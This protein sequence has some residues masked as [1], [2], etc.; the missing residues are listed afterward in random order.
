MNRDLEYSISINDYTNALR[1]FS[2]LPSN[3][4]KARDILWYVRSAIYNN[5]ASSLCRAFNLASKNK[6]P[7]HIKLRIAKEIYSN[8]YRIMNSQNA[9]GDYEI[10]EKL[11]QSNSQINIHS[12]IKI[13]SLLK[14]NFNHTFKTYLFNNSNKF[15][16]K[17]SYSGNGYVN[18]NILKIFNLLDLQCKKNI[19]DLPTI[20]K[21]QE[22]G[23]VYVTHD[24]T[25]MD[26]T[27]KKILYNRY[28]TPPPKKP[29]GKSPAG[30]KSINI[31]FFIG[32]RNKGFYHWFI[33]QFPLLVYHYSQ[34]YSSLPLLFLNNTKL[35]AQET[36]KLLFKPMPNIIYVGDIIKVEKLFVVK[37]S[38]LVLSRRKLNNIVYDPL[39]IN[40]KRITN[41]FSLG[42]KIYISR[43]KSVRRKF[44]NEN[45]LEFHLAK[46]DFK[47]VCLEDLPLAKQISLISNAN[48]IAAC[49]GSGLAHIASCKPGT[50]IF[51]IIP[52]DVS[53]SVS[54]NTWQNKFS[55]ISLSRMLG[56]NHRIYFQYINPL[57][58]E[59][60]L[61]IKNI[62]EDI[63]N[64]IDIK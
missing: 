14:N 1:I 45:E 60:N 54:L 7:A 58:P 10:I 6:I 34:N 39:V 55:F 5:D 9:F 2:D 63:N 37:G 40:S 48:I 57:K 52:T 41:N 32:N 22:F 31:A 38:D 43:K 27:F 20:P 29:I 35:F 42:N 12:L 18:K 50:K 28:L 30:V 19:C 4:F 24:G 46:Y 25:V 59:Y 3:H 33:E 16:S 47:A 17:I 23:N 51:E 64:F 26:E 15:N 44:K 13:K 56:F 61:D 62:I 21:V 8:K 49:H 53:Y 36:L 11:L